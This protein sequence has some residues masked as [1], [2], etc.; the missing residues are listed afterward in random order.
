MVQVNLA[1]GGV[2]SEAN[3]TDIHEELSFAAT[4]GQD[5]V[6]ELCVSLSVP[7]FRLHPKPQTLMPLASPPS[8]VASP[9]FLPLFLLFPKP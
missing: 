3:V 9:L 8:V 1:E 4:P 7:L 2:S 6:E 5:R